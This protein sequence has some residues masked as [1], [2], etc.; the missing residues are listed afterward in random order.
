[1]TQYGKMYGEEEAGEKIINQQVQDNKIQTVR[2]VSLLAVIA[3]SA[4]QTKA[5]PST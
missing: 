4:E 3:F 1:M 2:V 5:L